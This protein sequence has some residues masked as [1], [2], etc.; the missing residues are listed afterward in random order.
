MEA[1]LVRDAG[2]NTYEDSID[3]S[4]G[5]ADDGASNDDV[6][7]EAT[8][9]PGSFS[10]GINHLLRSFLFSLIMIYNFD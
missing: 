6:V 10:D 3:S 5:E 7:R 8:L 2:M 4:P 1:E 9:N